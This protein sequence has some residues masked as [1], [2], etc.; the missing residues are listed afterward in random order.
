MVKI[1]IVDS[2]RQRRMIVEGALVAPWTDELVTACKKIRS[3]LYGREL[4]V[5]VRGLTMIS[6]DGVNALLQLMKDKTK[7]RH[8]VYVRELLR[9]LA[10]DTQRQVQDV[11]DPLNGAGS[12][13]EDDQD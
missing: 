9:Q 1:S 8:G 13:P 2:P 7:V 6:P 3:D 5:D 4:V 12:E 10:H 11:S